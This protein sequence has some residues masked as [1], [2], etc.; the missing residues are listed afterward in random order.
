VENRKPRIDP[1]RINEFA[2]RYADL[3]GD[4]EIEALRD[5]IRAR[6]FL[7]LD[8]LHQVAKW[9]AARN[10]GRVLK[11]SEEYIEEITRF[12]LKTNCEQARIEVPTCLYGVSWPMASVILHFFHEDPYPILDYRALWSVG[13][14]VPGQ[15]GF[16]FWW[17]YVKVCREMAVRN[18]VDMR[19]LDRALWQYA[20]ERQGRFG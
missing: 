8:E 1:A 15:Y 9:K 3:Q 10:A 19:T 20:K 11:N 18:A 12:A 2:S 7:I 4:K 6:G 14:D 13:M 5:G 16:A 17:E